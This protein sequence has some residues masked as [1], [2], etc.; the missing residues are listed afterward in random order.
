MI[1]ND[2]S[3]F[4][5][6]KFKPILKRHLKDW[7]SRSYKKSQLLF[8]YLEFVLWTAGE[9]T[10]HAI[11]DEHR[12]SATLIQHRGAHHFNISPFEKIM[13]L[14]W[15]RTVK[16]SKYGVSSVLST[17]SL[18]TFTCRHVTAKYICACFHCSFHYSNK[19]F[20]TGFFCPFS[21]GSSDHPK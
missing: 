12:V 2:F 6:F 16:L 7:K 19:S 17:P 20:S 14:G 4:Q 13:S 8:R 21:I 3:W 9:L 11:K 5:T 1:S 10:A 18:A 15:N